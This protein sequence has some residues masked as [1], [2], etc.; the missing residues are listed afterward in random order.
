MRRPLAIAAILV[1]IAGCAHAPPEAA[2]SPPARDPIAAPD[3][4][5]LEDIFWN[6]D[7][8]ATTRGVDATPVRECTLATR[9]LRRIKF[10]NSFYRMLEWWRENKPAE[11][12][13]RRLQR[14]DSGDL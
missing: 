6:C 13:K 8:V 3:L 14:G 1:L 10:D 2:K 4:A 7:Y 11:H 12:G 9:E 5:L